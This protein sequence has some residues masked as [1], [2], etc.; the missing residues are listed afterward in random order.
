[1]WFCRDFMDARAWHTPPKDIPC[2]S[3]VSQ[4]A[5]LQMWNQKHT[6]K[7][8]AKLHSYMWSILYVK[9]RGVRARVRSIGQRAWCIRTRL[10]S[11]VRGWE[12]HHFS[13][14]RVLDT[15]ARDDLICHDI[16]HIVRRQLPDW[17]CI[18]HSTDGCPHHR[19]LQL[20]RTSV[21]PHTLINGRSQLHF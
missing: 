13:W 4:T 15:D 14:C 11:G 20:P 12:S 5:N 16:T 9:Y 6:Y 18:F 1:M 8:G 17:P 2:C 7:C 3:H 10:M 21:T 19:H